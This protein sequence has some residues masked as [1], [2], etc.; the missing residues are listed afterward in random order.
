MAHI[1]DFT[2]FPIETVKFFRDLE[3]NNNKQWFE[4][5]KTVY[6]KKVLEP[7]QA[8][9]VAMGKRLATVSPKV[10]ADPRVNQSIFRIY[11]DTRFSKDKTPYKTHLGIFLWE[12]SAKKMEN[13]GYYIQVD[14]RGIFLGV[15][16]YMFSPH[17][18][19]A[20]REAVVDPKYGPALI[21]AIE[22]A[23]RNP[24]YHIGGEKYKRVPRGYDPKH[25]L[26]DWLLFKGL[27]LYFEDTHPEELHSA[28]FADFCFQKLSDISPLHHWMRELT[29]RVI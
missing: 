20:Y 25:P 8:F 16:L 29:E 4:D 7:A 28:T 19:E 21:K 5:H 15:G 9:V 3:K 26:S 17:I 12:G 23:T 10:V 22:S 11:R 13:S 6:Q 1:S 14:T 27:Y 24:A 2:G 18:I